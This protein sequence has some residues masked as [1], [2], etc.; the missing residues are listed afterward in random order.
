MAM[1]LPGSR[2]RSVAV[3]TSERATTGSLDASPYVYL[4]HRETFYGVTP[5]FGGAQFLQ[6]HFGSKA[7]ISQCKI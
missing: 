7:P 2:L 5:N 6:K 3:Q 4:R 1:R